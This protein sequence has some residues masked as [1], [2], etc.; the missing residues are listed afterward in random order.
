MT[1]KIK[2]DVVVKYT[3][4]WETDYL[5]KGLNYASPKHGYCHTFSKNT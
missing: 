4:I 5:I 3:R 2:E 1:S